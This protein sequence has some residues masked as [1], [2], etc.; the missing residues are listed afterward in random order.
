MRRRGILARDAFTPPQRSPERIGWGFWALGAALIY[1]AMPIGMQ[2]ALTISGDLN[3]VAPGEMTLRAMGVAVMGS[4]IVG[5]GAGVVLMTIISR[6]APDLGFRLRRTDPL[7][8]LAAL[9]AAMPII[10]L[11]SA[12]ASMLDSLL[13]GQPPDPLAHETL[14]LMAGQQGSTWWW[15]TVVGVVVAAPI[16]EELLYRG[17]LQSS[18][19]ALVGS[20][21][22]AIGVTSVIF[23]AAHGG[24]AD[25]RALPGLLALSIVLGVAFERKA[26]IGVPVVMHMLFNAFNVV[27]AT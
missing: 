27:I 12:G 7:W 14:R 10:L 18:L 13:T 8:A 4:S 15:V 11:I 21:W 9:L 16:A 3:A 2:I 24:I 26:R 6:N 20:R 25:W 17:F 5:A 22:L 1:L 19:V 23:A